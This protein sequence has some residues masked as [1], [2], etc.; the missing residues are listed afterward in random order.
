MT[1]F[2]DKEFGGLVGFLLFEAQELSGVGAALGGDGCEHARV[3][4]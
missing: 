3:P 2:H 1:H 4:L